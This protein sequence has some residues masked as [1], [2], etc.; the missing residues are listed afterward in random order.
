MGQ[1]NDSHYL[2]NRRQERGDSAFFV[3]S[4]KK[5]DHLFNKH[6]TSVPRAAGPGHFTFSPPRNRRICS[7]ACP[8]S[9]ARRKASSNPPDASSCFYNKLLPPRP[10]T[11]DYRLP[12]TDY[13][14]LT[15]APRPLPS[16][17]PFQ[18]AHP[19][20]RRNPVEKAALPTGSQPRA[21]P[22]KSKGRDK[23]QPNRIHRQTEPPT[24]SAPPR[25]IGEARMV[26]PCRG[27][28]TACSP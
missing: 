7:M 10:L 21:S 5:S 16:R 27:R 9:S 8:S 1:F 11:T 28:T 17:A 20:A 13:R 19:F 4:C 6:Q 15:P 26:N 12:I 14:P 24:A 18:R 3:S 22:A 2:D 25:R 23:A